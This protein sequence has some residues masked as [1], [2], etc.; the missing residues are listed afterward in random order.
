MS[1]GVVNAA[2]RAIA[3]SM[4]GCQRSALAADGGLVALDELGQHLAAEQLD[5]TP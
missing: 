5:A 1:C 4:I 3:A 2:L